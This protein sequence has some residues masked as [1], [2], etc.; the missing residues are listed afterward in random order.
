MTSMSGPHLEWTKQIDETLLELAA[1]YPYGPNRVAWAKVFK[2]PLWK[3]H[4]IPMVT[5]RRRYNSIQ[6]NQPS[7]KTTRPIPQIATHSLNYCPNCGADL[8]AFNA[9]LHVSAAL[10]GAAYA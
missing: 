5:I 3:W 9:A 7:K 2:D 4:K 1:K 10:N 6:D 8:A